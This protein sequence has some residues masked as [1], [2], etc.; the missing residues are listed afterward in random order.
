MPTV[1]KKF[2]G[3][4][5]KNWNILNDF[6]NNHQSIYIYGAGNLAEGYYEAL[7]LLGKGIKGFIV[8][9][10]Q[11]DTYLGVPIFSIERALKE[12]NYQDGIIPA[13]T[14]SDAGMIATMTWVSKPD[15]LN[16]EH[17]VM[18]SMVNE[19][20]F[21]PLLNGLT[22]EYP[23]NS[24]KLEAK[25][26]SKILI[27]RLDAIGDL[28]FITP[29]L[30]EIKRNLPQASIQ[31]AIRRSNASLV[32]ECPYIDKLM[33]YND[34][35]DEGE[36]FQQCKEANGIR[37]KVLKFVEENKIID[38]QYDAVFMTR[39]CLCGRNALAEF[40]LL[41]MCKSKRRIG[42]ILDTPFDRK[43]IY[44]WVRNDF[45]VFCYHHYPMHESQYVLE[46]LRICGMTINDESMELWIDE[47]SRDKVKSIPI[48]D[49]SIIIAL[50][51]VSG[52]STR[53][54][55]KNNYVELIKKVRNKHTGNLLF[56]LLGGNDALDSACEI[57]NR[58]GTTG[59]INLAGKLNLNETVAF[60]ER[61]SI[62][63]G[64]NT[65][66][67]HMASAMRKP[68]VT[69]YSELSDGK[70][71]DGDAPERMGAWMVPHID[72]VPP[73]GLDGCHGVCRMGFAHCIQLITPD[74]VL[75]AIEELLDL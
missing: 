20:L 8:T 25:S 65:G 58:C 73:S 56:F 43:G 23:L 35:Q 14:N 51:I 71:T 47:S 42:H 2:G 33:L 29:F 39:E 18:I 22:R 69:I 57:E 1:T 26:W 44:M 37:E 75:K 10:P 5:K 48:N 32:K 61:S 17:R 16:F 59:I 13:F 40:Y 45:T 53:T 3:I 11:M 68:S 55:D 30:R 52:S 31:L 28:I 64:S 34:E 6:I 15:I 63:V 19:I 41:Y 67:L 62:Y 60:I 66:L 7:R 12:L 70:P 9:S 24:R 27:T 21:V 36:L 72:L 74:M 4:H 38:E 49:D 46:M 54:W 50:G